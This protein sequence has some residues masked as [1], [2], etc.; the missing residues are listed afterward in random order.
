MIRN[1]SLYINKPRLSFFIEHIYNA[2]MKY[3]TRGYNVEISNTTTNNYDGPVDVIVIKGQMPSYKFE[4][5]RD[6]LY[7]FMQAQSTIDNIYISKSDLI[8]RSFIVSAI[9][10]AVP[11]FSSYYDFN[12]VVYVKGS[13]MAGSSYIPEAKTARPS[14]G[15]AYDDFEGYT[16]PPPADFFESKAG[17]SSD[18]YEEEIKN[19]D[20]MKGQYYTP[21]DYKSSGPYRSKPNSWNPGPMPRK[22][23]GFGGSASY[24]RPPPRAPSPP[25]SPPRRAPSPPPSPR[26][27]PEHEHEPEPEPEDYIPPP[28]PRESYYQVKQSLLNLEI[29]PQTAETYILNKGNNKSEIKKAFLKTTLKYHPDKHVGDPNAQQYENKLKEAVNSFGYLKDTGYAFS[30]KSRRRRYKK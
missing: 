23:P 13:D 29:D 18:F 4:A 28:P 7:D 24:S 3:D 9:S 19:F 10:R 2:L 22:R 6:W 17:P 12:V 1:S 27:E 5:F 30:K 25:R 26:A 8:K 14:G 15:S 20:Y 16:V 11:Y 21:G